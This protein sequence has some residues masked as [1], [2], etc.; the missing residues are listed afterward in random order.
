[1]KP[2]L[3]A[4]LAGLLALSL[5]LPAQAAAPKVFRYAF[6]IA[7][8]GFDPAQ[9][10]DT[11]SRTITPHIFEALYGY[12]PLAVPVRIVPLTAAAAPEVSADFKTFTIR[13]RPG[14]FFTDDAAFKGAHPGK[15]REL[16][17][18]DYVY[19]FKRFADPAVKS[20]MWVAVEEQGIV[21]L[22]ELRRAALKDKRAFDYDRPIEGLRALDRYTLQFKLAQPRPRLVETLAYNDLFGAMAREVVEAYGGDIA[23]HPVGTGPFVLKSWR[24]SSQIVLERNPAYRERFFESQPAADDAEGLAIAARLRGRRLPMID[25][26]EIS[27]IEESQPRWLSFLNG[28]HDFIDRVPPEFVNVALPNGKI[29]P[30]LA[31]RGIQLM[32]LLNADSSFVYFNMEDPTVGG[33]TADKVA[34]RRALSLAWDVGREI[35]LLRRGQAVIAQSLVLPHT[36]GYDPQYKSEM[37]DYDPARANALLDLYGY[38]DRDGDGWRDMPDGSP[39]LLDWATQPDS[40]SRAFDEMFRINM[41]RIH[42]R[43]KFSPAKWPEQLKQARA[44]KLMLWFLGT[45]A[46]QPDGINALQRMYGPQAGNQNLGR[47]KSAEFDALYDRMQALPDG[48]EREALFLQ[49]KRIQVAL[50]PIKTHVHRIV[51]DMA[52]PWVIGYRRP[53]FR[54]EFWQY[55]DIDNSLRPAAGR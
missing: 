3:R 18:A 34:L 12:D 5:L 46:P 9:I 36:S 22:A 30:N 41:E 19:S 16:V 54:N 2:W 13:L 31:K 38:V 7:E 8:T 21:G 23:A 24:R 27:I 45:T 39:L 40:L 49:A 53:L 43:T 20:P 47:F 15:G 42:V 55:I 44:G 28:E 50:M 32:R 51:N 33:Y 26:V 37:G 35:R 29:A 17:A 52:Q 14:I 25:R 6:L 10:S 11:Y 48:P 1:M 4:G